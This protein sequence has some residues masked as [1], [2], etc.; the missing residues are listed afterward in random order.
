MENNHSKKKR[1]VNKQALTSYLHE[2]TTKNNLHS[3]IEQLHND[4]KHEYMHD[5]KEKMTRSD[6]EVYLLRMP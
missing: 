2:S 3:S 1:T 4:P 6:C 5:N